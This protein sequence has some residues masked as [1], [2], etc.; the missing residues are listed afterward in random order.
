[1]MKSQMVVEHIPTGKIW[2]GKMKESTQEEHD[3]NV[4]FIKQVA[5]GGNYMFMNEAAG[6]VAIPKNIIEDCV[7]FMKIVSE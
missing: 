1:M 4:D 2:A 5:K 7:L 6:V 3:D